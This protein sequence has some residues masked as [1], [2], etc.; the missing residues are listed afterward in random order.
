MIREVA[1]G[2]WIEIS[3]R[4][5]DSQDLRNLGLGW[6][7]NWVS[8]VERVE[9]FKLVP[10]ALPGS[11]HGL[12]ALARRQDHVEVTLLECS[13]ENVG[14]GK[15]FDR[16]AGC[17]LAFAV[18]LSLSLGFGGYLVLKAKTRLINTYKT[19]YGF[20]RLGQSHRMILAPPA[21]AKL[22]A[23]YEK[24]RLMDK[25]TNSDEIDVFVEGVESD[26]RVLSETSRF[27]AHH[28]QR[29]AYQAELEEAR[30]ILADAGIDPSD[31]GMPD[32]KSL[33]D[34]WHRCIADLDGTEPLPSD[35]EYAGRRS[36]SPE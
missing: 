4:P 35:A 9:V 27:I 29:P 8:E 33:L 6:N 17:L 12:I 10:L 15:R 24:G 16:I 11:I 19:K 20:E 32:A 31:D 25:R 7:S 14:S 1:T 36:G 2:R 18:R 13:P 22:I 28:K 34:H 30:K 5:I 3:V 21:T 26:P 23:E